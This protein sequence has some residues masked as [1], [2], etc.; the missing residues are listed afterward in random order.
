MRIIPRDVDGEAEVRIPGPQDPRL[1]PSLFHSRYRVLTGLRKAVERFVENHVK[2]RGFRTVLDVGA[3]SA[4]YRPLLVP[5]VERYTTVDLPGTRADVELTSEGRV[6]LRDAS[7]DVLLSNQVL[8]HVED[9]RAHVLELARLLDPR[10]ILL[11]S[12]HGHWMYHPS[13]ADYWRWTGPGLRRTLEGAGFEVVDTVGVLGRAAAGLQLFHDGV[14]GAIP[15]RLRPL[16]AL[17]LAGTMPMVDRLDR[18]NRSED[19]SVF[20]ITARP[21]RGGM[22]A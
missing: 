18:S 7:A 11:L 20:V 3:G 16:L 13:P 12:T 22:E 8:E 10:G 2:G 15:A 4:P 6:P 9:P 19:A 1:Y 14:V 5:H 17:C 21:S